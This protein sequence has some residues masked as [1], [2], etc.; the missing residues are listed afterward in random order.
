MPRV[1]FLDDAANA[2]VFLAI[3]DSE[4]VERPD[5]ELPPFR[6]SLDA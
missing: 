3:R 5:V 1:E 4:P 2:L 6:A